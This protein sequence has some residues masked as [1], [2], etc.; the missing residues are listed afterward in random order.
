M[1]GEASVPQDS[2]QWTLDL[3]NDTREMSRMLPWLTQ[4][5]ETE[6][7]SEELVHNINLVLEEL[8]LNTIRYG[9]PKID[10]LAAPSNHWIRIQLQLKNGFWDLEITDDAKEFNPLGQ[11]APTKT[12]R[13]E[14]L[15]TGGF[16]IHLVRKLSH[17]VKYLRENDTNY[18]MIRFSQK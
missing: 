13:I 4:I 7:L 1:S 10:D 2:Q 14:D 3:K 15:K 6:S 18:I 8:I 9:Y 11:A 5:S 16:G 17:S 12:T